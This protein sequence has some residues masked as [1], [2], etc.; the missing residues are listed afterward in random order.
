[1]LNSVFIISILVIVLVLIT[2][3]YSLGQKI[4]KSKDEKEKKKLKIISGIVT[5]VGIVAIALLS[6]YKFTSSAE[7]ARNVYRF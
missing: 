7:I 3:I 5:S 2:V 1:M 4:K 6:Y